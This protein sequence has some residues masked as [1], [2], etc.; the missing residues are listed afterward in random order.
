MSNELNGRGGVV[1]FGGAEISDLAGW[2]WDGDLSLEEIKRLAYGTKRSIVKNIGWKVTAEIS[3]DIL[4]RQA[5]TIG[6]GT[7]T[8]FNL[9]EYSFEASAA[10]QET[11]GALD[12]WQTFNPNEMSWQL[13]A[14]RWD[15]ADQF[16]I[17]AAMAING[18]I[19]PTVTVNVATPFGNGI[20]VMDKTGIKADDNSIKSNLS[21]QSGSG[22]MPTAG[23]YLSGYLGY[24]TAAIQ[25][26]LT[27]GYAAPLQLELPR[28]GSG[29]AF[30]QKMKVTCP[31]GVIK[32]SLEFQGSGVFTPW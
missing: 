16:A 22:D 18:A 10:L 25:S 19:D 11:T 9:Q 17:F 5:G 24:I 8:G 30:L 27:Q 29:M 32:G 23:T 14:S 6:I 20:G 13:E 2:N 3:L 28:G 7:W 15:T 1:R 31:A 12:I 4:T 26:V 21:V